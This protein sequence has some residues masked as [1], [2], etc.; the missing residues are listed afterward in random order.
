MKEVMEYVR[1]QG[2]VS[3]PE[4][5]AKFSLSYREARSF[6]AGLESEHVGEF[7]GGIL[8]VCKTD[9]ENDLDRFFYEGTSLSKKRRRE[10]LKLKKAL[11]GKP[12][13]YVKIV[14]FCVENQ[15]TTLLS[16]MKEFQ[17]GFARA[18]KTVEWLREMKVLSEPGSSEKRVLLSMQ[19]FLFMIQSDGK[20]ENDE[21]DEDE[22]DE[23]EDEEENGEESSIEQK[24]VL[25][26]ARR[27]SILRLINAISNQEDGEDVEFDEEDDDEDGTYELEENEIDEEYEDDEEYEYED[28]DEES[29]YDEDDEDSE[30]EDCCREDV[31]RVTDGADEDCA[32]ETEQEPL[33]CWTVHTSRRFTQKEIDAIVK[34]LLAGDLSTYGL[35]RRV[36]GAVQGEGGMWYLFD[37]APTTLSFSIVEEEKI[38]LL[39]GLGRFCV[40]GTSLCKPKIAELFGISLV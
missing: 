19:E 1:R 22:E 9:E 28:E 35:I 7:D 37:F 36:H 38:G 18:K 23:D 40:V 11:A 16:L 27:S 10:L 32:E 6:L 21:E 39:R 29:E 33:D 20:I 24:R 4:L 34:T 12:P 5:Q 26:E 15:N 31:D 30:S 17:M 25:L 8:F 3:V 14:Q 2:S 13:L